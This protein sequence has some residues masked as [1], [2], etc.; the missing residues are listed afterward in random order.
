MALADL[1]WGI[2][3]DYAFYDYAGKVCIIGVFDRVYVRQLPGRLSCSF[4][5]RLVGEP[6]ERCAVRI[7]LHLPGGEVAFEYS[8]RI[9]L[10]PTGTRERVWPIAGVSLAS[11]GIGAVTV[12]IGGRLVRTFPFVVEVLRE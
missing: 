2:L 8:D 1:D 7:A 3:C 4:V 11:E 9:E 12:H 6:G 10:G 5:L